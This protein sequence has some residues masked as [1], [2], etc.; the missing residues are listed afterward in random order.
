MYWAIDAFEKDD[1]LGAMI[2]TGAK[3]PEGNDPQQEAFSSG[4]SCV[5]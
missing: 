2:I 1:S 4:G 5:L 3:K